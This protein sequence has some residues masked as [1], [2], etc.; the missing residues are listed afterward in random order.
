[1]NWLSGRACAL[2]KRFSAK[3]EEH[4]FND[5]AL[6]LSASVF[7]GV[8]R[9]IDDLEG[10]CHDRYMSRGARSINIMC[11]YQH[12]PRIPIIFFLIRT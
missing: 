5:A 9:V 11:V 3:S 1:M 7:N 4:Y 12:V 2:K 6:I 10:S 8:L